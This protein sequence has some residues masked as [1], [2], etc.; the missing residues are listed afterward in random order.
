MSRRFDLFLFSTNAPFARH[1]CEAGAAGVIIDWENRG[2]RERQSG[3]DTQVNR[4]TLADLIE[5]R[6]SGDH[7][8]VCRIN[9]FG[10]STNH[11]VE[12]AIRGGATEILLPMVREPHEVTEVLRMIGGRIRL[13]MLMETR[14]AAQRA[15][16]FGDLPL[17]RIYV[18]LN[19]L[20]IDLGNRTLFRALIDGTVDRIRQDLLRSSVPFGI[21]GMTLPECGSP[22]PC[23]L[24]AGEI[25]RLG[26]AFTFLRRSFLRDIAGRRPEAEIPRMLGE[27]DRLAQRSDAEV[28]RDRAEFQEAVEQAESTISWARAAAG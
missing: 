9:G 3:F 13:G 6:Q 12:A 23:L 21:G 16:E 20:S 11:E 28:I 4:D 10:P 25:A 8:I 7:A 1:C 27:L 2:K 18:G 24:L 17:S 26:S 5:A 14:D 19:D 15:A 22:I